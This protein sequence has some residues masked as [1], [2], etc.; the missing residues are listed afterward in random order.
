MRTKFC[1]K[2]K[3]TKDIEEFYRNQ[4]TCK[5]CN[6]NYYITNKDRILKQRKIYWIKNKSRFSNQR[7]KYRIE[8][9][10]NFR[11]Q[12]LKYKH[13]PPAIYKALKHCAKQRNKPFNL[14]KDFFIKWYKNQPKI[15]VYC[16]RK[17]KKQF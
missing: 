6:K 1:T 4:T 12:W 11:K 15:C 13:T 16:K 8:H 17:N 7:K 2:C 5:E 14:T 10:E 3:K 9:K